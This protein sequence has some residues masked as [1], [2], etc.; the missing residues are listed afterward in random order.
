MKSDKFESYR[1]ALGYLVVGSVVCGVI[2][3]GLLWLIWMMI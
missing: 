3:W 1:E 2:V